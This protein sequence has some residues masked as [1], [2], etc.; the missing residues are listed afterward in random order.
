M[1]LELA[2]YLSI[3]ARLAR[4]G[5]GHRAEASTA[6]DGRHVIYRLT[7]GASVQPCTALEACDFLRSVTVD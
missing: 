3:D 5:F 4:Q 2:R 6:K 7:D 1:N